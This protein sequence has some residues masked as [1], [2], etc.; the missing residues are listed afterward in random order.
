M[1]TT[2]V[3]NYIVHNLLG[4]ALDHRVLL[5]RSVRRG[6]GVHACRTA[7]VALSAGDASDPLDEIGLDLV[8]VELVVI[9]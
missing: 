7:A 8:A 4:G 3:L 6:G 5:D 9:G 2:V 1:C